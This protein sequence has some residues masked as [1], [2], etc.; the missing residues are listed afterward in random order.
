MADIEID[1]ETNR[2][3]DKWVTAKRNR[4]YASADGIR[5]ALEAKGI[6]AEQVRPHVYEPPGQG[7]PRED[8]R[9]G[10]SSWT[11]L[12][13]T[14][15]DRPSPADRQEKK[16][17]QGFKQTFGYV[18]PANEQPWAASLTSNSGKIVQQEGS[19][20]PVTGKA[21]DG[22]FRPPGMRVTG[23]KRTGEGGGFREF[24]D[25]EATRRKRRALEVKAETSAR[26]AEKKK[27]DYWCALLATALRPDP[28][29]QNPS[30]LPRQQAGVVHLLKHLAAAEAGA[31]AMTSRDALERRD[32]LA[33][34]GR[35]RGTRDQPRMARR[36]MAGHGRSGCRAKRSSTAE[37]PRCRLGAPCSPGAARP[38]AS[39]AANGEAQEDPAPGEA[40][41]RA[42]ETTGGRAAMAWRWRPTLRPTSRGAGG[43]A[44]MCRTRAPARGQPPGESLQLLATPTVLNGQSL[45]TVIRVVC[46]RLERAHT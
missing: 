17:I 3:L 9:L 21:V 13:T 43:R 4:D 40:R 14:T 41:E 30:R 15:D 36:A 35:G 46:G 22:A 31:A 25:A 34:Q 27:C 5:A 44:R 39:H 6:R 24:D 11:A 7:R 29:R 28:A 19:I 37:R 23:E 33:R 20:V 42:A 32:A 38:D 18:P 16:T 45:C 1:E 10:G 12:A 2:Q 8:R 26:K